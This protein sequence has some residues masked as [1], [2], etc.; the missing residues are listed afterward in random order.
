MNASPPSRTDPA[1]P[2]RLVVCLA[3]KL[4]ELS[5]SLSRT[6][7]PYAVPPDVARGGP[8]SS[9]RL[10]GII[11][12]LHGSQSSFTWVVVPTL[13]TTT[14]STPI[15]GKLADLADRKK[16]IQLAL[17]ITV[18]SSAAAG[19]SHNVETL[20][21]MRAFQGIGTGGLT[22][23]GTVLIADIISPRERGKYLGLMG[24]VMGVAMIGG[25]PL[26]GVL[27]DGPGWLSVLEV[28]CTDVRSRLH[29]SPI[30][31]RTGARVRAGTLVHGPSARCLTTVK[32]C[33]A[34]RTPR[35]TPEDSELGDSRG[36]AD[37]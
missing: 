3:L 13:L 23:L 31:H 16:L 19:L 8:W 9:Q 28:A 4:R 32:W 6:D 33:R 5:T 34:A 15:W 18:L 12:D 14:V 37:R 25:P 21:T 24:A 35:G 20:I 26:G 2:A 30:G 36:A 7:L 17:T 27:T 1:A 11:S 10:P 22:A 29:E